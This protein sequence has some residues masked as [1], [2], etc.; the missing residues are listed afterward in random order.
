MA[1]LPLGDPETR[2]QF[3]QRRV[4]TRVFAGET[5]QADVAE[6]FPGTDAAVLEQPVRR[7]GTLENPVWIKWCSDLQ[8]ANS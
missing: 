2:S 8:W 5:E 3:F 4:T 6:L 1:R 7:K